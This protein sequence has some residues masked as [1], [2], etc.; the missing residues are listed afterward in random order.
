MY[1]NP[2]GSLMSEPRPAERLIGLMTGHW[3]SAAIYVMAEL[4]LADRIRAGVVS[5]Q[6]LAAEQD[7][8][9]RSVYRLLRALAGIGLVE[10]TGTREFALT[11]MGELLRS[12][13]PRS[14]RPS[15]LFQGSP[16]HWKGWGNLIHNVRTGESAFENAHGMSFF[17]YC[18]AHPEF[19]ERFNNAMSTGAGATSAAVAEAYD[20]AGISTLVDVGG[21]HGNLLTTILARFPRLNGI[22]TDLP[23]V[24]AGAVAPAALEGRMRVVPGDFF[25]SVPPGDAHILKNVIHDW[26]D[27]RATAILNVVRRATL[28]SGRLL[29]VEAIVPEGNAPSFAKMIDLEMMHATPGGVQRT[30]RELAKLFY[31]TGFRLERVIETSSMAS[32]LE[33][34]PV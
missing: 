15:I 24:V 7:L 2:E 11:P 31:S 32:V 1:I 18:K 25:E 9:E 14:M 10:E 13:H 6:R 22:L 21:G 19:G 28:D 16:T 5:T 12:D 26:D 8:Y 4:G 34:R 27:A 29:I 33:A 3:V 30:E 23:E 17:E 20:F